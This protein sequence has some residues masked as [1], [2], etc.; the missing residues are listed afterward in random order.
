MKKGSLI[1]FLQ[2]LFV[3]NKSS[4]QT[5]MEVNIYKMLC[6]IWKLQVYEL[7]DKKKALKESQRETYIEFHLDSTYKSIANGKIETGIWHYIP[8]KKEIKINDLK[9]ENKELTLILEKIDMKE[10]TL[11]MRQ[12]KE[13]MIKM[14]L[15]AVQ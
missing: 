7:K 4:G 15:E 2:L 8:A 11:M 6:K 9:E 3:I 5:G 14:F 10:C 12:G 13:G 1:I